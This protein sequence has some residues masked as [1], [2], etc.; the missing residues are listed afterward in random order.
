[1]FNGS[2]KRKVTTPN[3]GRQINDD[4]SGDL[5]SGGSGIAEPGRD[6]SV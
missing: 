3:E 2:I 1:L 4:R 6:A 5:R